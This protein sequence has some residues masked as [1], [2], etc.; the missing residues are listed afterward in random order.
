MMSLK[1]NLISVSVICF[2]NKNYNKLIMSKLINILVLSLILSITPLF[3]G[4]ISREVQN[5]LKNRFG[6]KVK[7]EYE[8]FYIP[9][10]IKNSIEKQV[11]QRFYK[12]YVYVFN[13]IRDGTTV[14]TAILDNV[15][16]K[17]MPIT[18]LVIF[19]SRGKIVKIKIIKY[20]EQYGGAVENPAWNKQFEGKDSN[21]DFTPGKTIDVITG[22][23][24]SVNS[25]SKGIRK[26]T[27]LF[28]EIKKLNENKSK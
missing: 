28:N 4:G 18:F 14:A 12:K 27:I 10:K 3:A 23:T 24:L 5:I 9:G 2:D 8:K 11:R 1:S 17:V 7:I 13:V 6:S 22:A 21:S 20:R 19:D 15:I 26:L 16:G 25:L